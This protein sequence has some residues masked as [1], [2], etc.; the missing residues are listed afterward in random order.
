M[1]NLKEDT[2]ERS[3]LIAAVVAAGGILVAGSVAS[4]A[5]INATASSQPEGTTTQIVAVDAPASPSTEAPVPFD[6]ATEPVILTE[7]SPEALPKV[8]V[9]KVKAPAGQVAAAQAPAA[10]A[11]SAKAK[12]KPK[13]S[14]TP[15]RTAEPVIEQVSEPE[16]RTIA[17]D[18]A[19]S[20]VLQATNGGVVESAKQASRAGYD[21]WAVS[22][23]RHDGSIITGY[24]DQS[25]GVV[26]DWVVT[27]EAPAPQPAAGSTSSGSNSSHDDD[28]HGDD[29]D[30][31]HGDDHGDDDD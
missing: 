19:V 30:D 25:Q 1:D 28:D 9:P 20:I 5:V 4:A 21:A 18:K 31:D 14:A 24:V 15:S 17:V 6:S 23:L 16:V 7:V 2:V 10:P 8:K 12:Q 26:F 22:V 27:Q 3:S 29:H 11:P 13:P